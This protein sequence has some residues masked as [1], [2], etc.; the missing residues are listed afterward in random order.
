MNFKNS[1]TL[2]LSSAYALFAASAGNPAASLQKADY[3]ADLYNWAEA[4]PLYLAADKSLRQGSPE[5]IHAHFGYLRSTMETRSLPELSNYLSA[6]LEL[7]V[8]ASNPRLRM[9]CLGIKGD[10]DGEMDS[11]SARADWEEAHRIAVQLGD[12]KWESRSLAEAGFN[13]YLMGDIATGRRNV[14]GALVIAHQT[15]DIGAEIR[16]L[17]AIGTGYE[18]N[19]DYAQAV[20]YFNKAFNFANGHPDSGYPFLTA[21]GEIETL[22]KKGDFDAAERLIKEASGV[23]QYR[24]KLI[25]LTQL[26][27]FQADI[28]IGRGQLEKA[29]QILLKTIP[30]ARR[31]QTRMLADAQMKLAQIYRQ[32]HKLALAE[33]YSAAAFA[34]TS[35]TKDLFTAPARL[36]FTAQLQWD[37]GRHTEARRSILRA[38][39][40][41]E[42]LLAQT[43]SGA[44]REGLLK[45]MSSAYE[46][47]F[48][49]AVQTGDTE[50]A[51]AIIERVRGRITAETLVQPAHISDAQFDVTLEDKIRNLKIRLIKAKSDDQ[52]NQLVQALFYAEQQRYL[53]DKPAPVYASKI[54]AVSLKRV[55]ENLG[56]REAL[57]EYV[58]LDAGPA[59][60]V[61]LTQRGASIVRLRPA[62]EVLTL[63]NTF[64]DDLKSERSWKQSARNLYDAVLSPVPDVGSY[65]RLTI[66]PDGS[67]HLVPFD[68]LLSPSGSLVGQTSVTAYAPSAVSD[69]LLKT[70]PNPELSQAFLGVGGAIY[71]RTAAKPFVLAESEKRRLSRNRSHKTSELAGFGK[72]S[73]IC[74]RNS[75]GAK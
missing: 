4:K 27:L 1:L 53:Q 56:K 72:R 5:Q 23:A 28:A 58:L 57:L 42:G 64:V 71:N 22:I 19:R 61:V 63:A 59:Y 13:A 3:Y 74:S 20:S 9:W 25:K 36:E 41:S 39:Q 43:S 24:D 70:R 38:L 55:T 68:A 75:S 69:F 17:S 15:G 32:Q 31:N 51:F 65:E 44:E 30:L 50:G 73:P 67:L 48:N 2:F 29:I 40:I 49:F 35:L 18:W 12:K 6:R 21:A 10:V 34:H 14:A 47:A 62:K 11:A 16:Y 54:E 37:L 46:T 7:P 45:E 60:C 52:R 33:H 26:D 8:V 66:V